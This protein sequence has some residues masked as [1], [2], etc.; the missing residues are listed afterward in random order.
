MNFFGCFVGIVAIVVGIVLFYIS[1]AMFFDKKKK[2]TID[3]AIVSTAFWFFG[4]IFI[5]GGIM[6]IVGA[7]QQF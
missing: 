1:L 5:L 4:S 3:D 7:M 2:P 6:A